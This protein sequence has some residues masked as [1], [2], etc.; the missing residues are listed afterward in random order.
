MG[1]F[2][3]KTQSSNTKEGSVMRKSTL[4]VLAVTFASLLGGHLSWAQKYDDKEHAELAKALKGVKTSLEKGLSA[5]ESQGKPISGKFEV[6]D[7]KLQLSVYTMKGDKFSEVIVDH[8]T[9]KV[10][11]TEA[12]TAGDDL[13]ASKSQSAAMAKAKLSLRAATENAVK[14]N[15]GFV[16][17]SVTPSLKDGH[18]VA[19]ITLAKGEEF[20]T[21]SEKLD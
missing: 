19:E 6:E 12:I 14:A 17:V 9:G 2:M 21:V 7:G 5:S 3:K 18:P 10:A 1:K 13:T 15:K 11:K 16:A 20:K 8:K 4:V